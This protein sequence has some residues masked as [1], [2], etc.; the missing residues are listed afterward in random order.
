[1]HDTKLLSDNDLERAAIA[2]QRSSAIRPAGRV[3]S[4]TNIWMIV[5]FCVVGMVCSL[6][7]P[8]AY[9]HIEQSSTLTAEAPLI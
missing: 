5:G 3:P 9:L 6:F 1:M 8:G 4:R 2:A 7:T